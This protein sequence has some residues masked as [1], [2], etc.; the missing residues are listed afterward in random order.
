[1]GKDEKMMANHLRLIK[2]SGSAKIVI[3]SKGAEISI[4]NKKVVFEVIDFLLSKLE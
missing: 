2:S 4:S 3:S 1:M